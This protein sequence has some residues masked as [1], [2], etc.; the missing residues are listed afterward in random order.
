MGCSLFRFKPDLWACT[1]KH[2]WYCMQ[3]NQ[4]NIIGDLLPTKSP[5]E[6]KDDS[7]LQM[8]FAYSNAQLNSLQGWILWDIMKG[9]DLVWHGPIFVKII[10]PQLGCLFCC[11]QTPSCILHW[12][13]KIALLS[14]I[15]MY[16]DLHCNFSNI[17]SQ[18]F[19][20]LECIL[21]IQTIS[22]S[23]SLHHEG[24]AV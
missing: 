12:L 3:N 18:F 10:F 20:F 6:L 17:S 11:W 7:N 22:H 15:G 13:G 5:I 19:I 1:T 8:C 14:K 23:W 16:I 24:C 4:W 21:F 2:Y 9:Q